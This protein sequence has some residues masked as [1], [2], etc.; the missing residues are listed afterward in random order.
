MKPC[1]KPIPLPSRQYGSMEGKPSVSF[2]SVEFD[3]GASCFL[4]S[5]IAKF[6]IGR[7]TIDTIRQTFQTNW[8]IKGRA[9]LTE[10]WDGR[11]LLVILDSEDDM[12]A[13]LTSPIR[14][15]QY[16]IFRL[17]RYTSDYNPRQESNITT[18]WIRLP[19]LPSPLFHRTYIGACELFCVFRRC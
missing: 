14:K 13:A 10:I 6:T 12:K 3:A 5:F 17:F 2:T 7:P 15:V 11:H 9:T 4:H 8:D 18:K 16:A 1:L 19:G